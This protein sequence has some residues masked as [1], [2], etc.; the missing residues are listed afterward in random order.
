MVDKKIEIDF[1]E[2]AFLVEACIPPCPIARATIWSDTIDKHYHK[3]TKNGRARMYDW[4][5]RNEKFKIQLEKSDEDC[6][7]FNAR[8]NPE[9]Q[10]V[11]HTEINGKKQETECFLFYGIFHTSSNTHIVGDYITGHIKKLS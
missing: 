7:L 4:M 8:F 11:V 2:L 9:N 1:I 10:Y 5:N 6:L 3:L